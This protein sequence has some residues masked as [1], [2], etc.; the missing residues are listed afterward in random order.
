MT[1]EK[2]ENINSLCKKYFTPEL[3]D[4]PV[5]ESKMSL[6]GKIY[7]QL[8]KY[9]DWICDKDYASKGGSALFCEIVIN[10]VE[11]CWKNWEIDSRKSYS[12]YFAIS[13]KN[14]VNSFLESKQGQINST[15]VSLDTPIGTDESSTLLDKIEDKMSMEND[16]EKKEIAR[17]NM[18]KVE[19]YLKAV[20]SWFKIRTRQDWNK[21]FV[22]AELYAGLHQY[23][24]YYPN[25]KI[26][27][28]SFIDE[29]IYNL[30]QEPMNKELAIIIGKSE[31]QLTHKRKEFREQVGFLFNS[32]QE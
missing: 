29:K 23:F 28:F 24:D 19:D 31:T 6:K 11:K 18:K 30:P 10:T 9:G 25:K 17:E 14:N 12:A 32:S 4:E 5:T 1:P 26:T 16:E 3:C 15:A 27:R 13:V 7:A 2:E 20:D 21:S 22:T 8:L